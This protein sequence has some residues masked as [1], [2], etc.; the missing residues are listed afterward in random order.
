MCRLGAVSRGPRVAGRR[1][2]EDRD[3]NAVQYERNHNFER[4]VRV[5]GRRADG[6]KL[7]FAGL[8]LNASKSESE[9][10]EW[11]DPRSLR[12]VSHLSPTG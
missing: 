10:K 7:P 2:D 3:G 4:L 11:F 6:A 9:P 1:S 12:N 5:L 8:R